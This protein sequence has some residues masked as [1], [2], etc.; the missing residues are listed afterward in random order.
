MPAS[1]NSRA[2]DQFVL[3]G[4]VTGAIGI[5]GELRVKTF[6]DMPESLADYGSLIMG[7][8]GQEKAVR[9]VRVV[10]G[11]VGLFLDGVAD[12][13]AAEALKGTELGITRATLGETEDDE[14]F[15]YID[16]MGLEVRDADGTALG[17]VKAVHDY[18][19]GAVL[20]LDLNDKPKTDLV[21]FRKETVP[22]VDLEGGFLVVLETEWL[23]EAPEEE[24]EG[25]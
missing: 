21:P 17:L 4:V 20:E 8:G 23:G 12:R 25:E 1:P 13:N 14:E 16:L 18:G 9:S 22:Q 7:A 2:E 10:K 6:T 19:G 24:G 15:F 3:L 5:R 11:G